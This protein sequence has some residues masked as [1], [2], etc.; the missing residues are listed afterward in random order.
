ML[1]HVL[2]QNYIWIFHTY[3]NGSW[4]GAPPLAA[5]GAAAGLFAAT[6][7]SAAIGVV[8]VEV[9]ARCCFH[10]VNIFVRLEIFTGSV[11]KRVGDKMTMTL[12]KFKSMF[13]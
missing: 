5:V 8:E 4:H 7:P 3:R 6:A 2:T 13:L 11:R 1:G 10:Q 12:R 9:A